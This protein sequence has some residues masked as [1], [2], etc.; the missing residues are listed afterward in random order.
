MK[1]V[2]K[3]QHS[4]STIALITCACRDCQVKEPD[5]VIPHF[6]SYKHAADSGWAM[7]IDQKYCPPGLDG[8]WICPDCYAKL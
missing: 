4:D 5:K 6:Y 7:S 8:A 2:A 1:N 3:V